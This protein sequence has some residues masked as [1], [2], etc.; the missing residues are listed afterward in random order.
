VAL[1][2]NVLGWKAQTSPG[3]PSAAPQP[4]VQKVVFDGHEFGILFKFFKGANEVLKLPPYS[5][6]FVVQS[7]NPY[8]RYWRFSKQ[9]IYDFGKELIEALGDASG[10]TFVESEESF[11]RKVTEART[12]VKAGAFAEDLKATVFQLE[13][14][15]VVIVSS[16]HLGVIA[17]AK[18][19][20]G[21]YLAPM[22]AWKIANASPHV[23]RQNLISE[24]GLRENQVEV[25]AGFYGMVDENFVPRGNAGA[26]ISVLASD[27]PEAVAKTEEADN[28]VYLAVTSPLQP[29]QLTDA[30]IAALISR[31]ELYDYQHEGVR[32]L[33]RNTS[34]LLADDMGLGKTRQAICAAHILSGLDEGG[35]VLVACPASLLINWSREIVKSI[36][37]D[38]TVSIG[39]YDPKAKWI[40]VNYDILADVVPYA[41]CFKVMILD[42][43]HLLKEPT[44]QRTRHAF[45]IAS[46]VPYRA[47]LTGTPILNRESEIHTL[48]RLSGHAIGAIPLREFE[49]QFS[50]D[51]S[52]RA[53]L[54]ER[55]N[56]WMLRRTKDVVLKHLK[57]KQRQAVYI[58]ITDAQRARYDGINADASILTLPKITM[59][60]RELESFKVEP[61]VQMVADMNGDDK[62]LIFCEFKET[63]SLMRKAFAARGIEYE[64]M[65]GDMSGSRRQ[66]AVDRFQDDPHK[67]VFILITGAGAVG[68]NLTAANYVF[69]ASLPWTPALAS[70]A[71]D[72]AYRNGQL[73]L[74]ISKIPLVENSI[75]MNLVAMH[76]DKQMIAA[77]VTDPDEA[78]RLAMAEFA[79]GFERLA[80]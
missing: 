23:V 29:T 44:A 7:T 5:G 16:Y 54:N 50:G 37:A 59:L 32:H 72:R 26:T 76:Q 71:E 30:Q 63:V 65:T 1:K 75:D 58:Q 24:L 49:A 45:D 9:V 53:L 35:Q 4:L 17:V 21:R 10:G 43:A 61:I 18:A 12:D 3:T 31:Y 70:Q 2:L 15:G 42:E 39:A 47:L 68:W 8:H 64:W 51:P 62:V 77:Q 28:E 79:E 27:M 67:R 69:L 55:I 33:V 60:R 80:A 13:R 38:E 56:E 66:N 57:G 48:L 78:E 25:A 6:R 34:S 14:G 74:V 19:M 36:G 46:K 11:F 73:R 22:K 20:G 41:H 52:F 40:I